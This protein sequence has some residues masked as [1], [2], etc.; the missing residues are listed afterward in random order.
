M[1]KNG[2]YK[3]LYEMDT[4]IAYDWLRV[5]V[6]AKHPSFQIALLILQTVFVMD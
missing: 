6:D 5:Q 4:N 2:K 1:K 3:Y